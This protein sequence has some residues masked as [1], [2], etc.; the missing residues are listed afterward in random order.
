MLASSFGSTLDQLERIDPGEPR[1][2]AALRHNVRQLQR[3]SARA[4]EALDEAVR[5]FESSRS[6]R[7]TAPLRRLGGRVR[8]S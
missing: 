2:I 4:G 3:E 7:L 6:W 1:E 8:A 5:G